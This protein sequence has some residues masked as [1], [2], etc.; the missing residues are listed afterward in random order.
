[1]AENYYTTLGVEKTATQ[2]EIKKAYRKM[3][4]KYHPDK[5]GGD[6]EQFKKVNEAYQ[7]LGDEQKKAQYDQFG[8]TFEGG[9]GNPFEGQGFGGFEGVNINFEDLGGI[10]DIFSEFFGGGSRTRTRQRVRRGQD[11]HVDTRISFIDSAKGVKENLSHRIYQT[12]EHCHGN[13]AEPGTPIKDCPT[14]SGTGSVS[15]TRQTPFG[16]FAT[17][18]PCQ[19]CQ[20]EGKKAETQC[21]ECRG[22]GRVLQDRSIEVE[23]PAGI[24]DGQA[25]R[26]TGKG[27]AP[28]KGGVAGDL[29]VTVHV[30]PHKTM[31]RDGNDIRS[32]ATISFQQAALG[33]KIPVTTIEGEKTIVIPPGTQPGKEL[34]IDNLGFQNLTTRATG[35]HIVSVTV[36][37]PKRLNR[38]QKQLLE[39]FEKAGQK[40]GIFS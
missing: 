36:E 15:Q 12:C 27:E 5:D 3:A 38:K 11:I 39:E 20:G 23:I 19:E 13:G 2:E 6:E 21:N 16:V 17:N 8:Q 31:R 30:E 28:P 10:G 7:V 1:M 40:K 33:T 25:V 14:C 24:A 9:G 35:D 37:V 22:Q 18:A 4:H 34:H 29:Y 32:T 26:M